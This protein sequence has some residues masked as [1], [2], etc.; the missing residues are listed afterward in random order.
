LILAQPG[1]AGGMRYYFHVRI[2]GD[3]IL[4]DEGIELENDELAREEAIKSAAELMREYPQN[5]KRASPQSISV[6]D[7]TGRELFI[8]PINLR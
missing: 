6:A 8:V 1:D 2:E 3:L 5:V 4:D 7:E